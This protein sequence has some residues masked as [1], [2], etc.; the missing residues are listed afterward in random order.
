M[1][2]RVL[3]KKLVWKHV[4]S[5]YACL[6]FKCSESLEICLYINIH[7]ASF[8]RAVSVK[9]VSTLLN[10]RSLQE[11]LV[12]TPPPTVEAGWVISR[13]ESGDKKLVD[14]VSINVC[15]GLQC[16]DAFGHFGVCRGWTIVPWLI[17]LIMRIPLNQ[18]GFCG[19]GF[20]G[21]LEK[22][23][24]FK[25]PGLG[26]KIVKY[27]EFL[28]IVCQICHPETCDPPRFINPKAVLDSKP[29]GSGK[30]T[31]WSLWKTMMIPS[32]QLWKV[33]K[34]LISGTLENQRARG[35]CDYLWTIIAWWIFFNNTSDRP[36]I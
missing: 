1:S 10:R 6:F 27:S 12:P 7:W 21:A 11:T 32:S 33:W 30:S 26:R 19:S 15:K 25:W 2:S 8:L 13:H 16:K 4:Y 22:L 18:T 34:A 28:V 23:Y 3:K 5:V 24:R 35:G 14:W 17:G 20:R 9:A 31:R 36:E 29:K